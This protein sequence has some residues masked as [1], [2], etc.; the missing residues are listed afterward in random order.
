M[1]EPKV[2]E[3]VELKHSHHMLVGHPSE[4]R[5]NF[6]DMPMMSIMNDSSRLAPLNDFEINQRYA[7]KFHIHG[8][9]KYIIW[10]MELET[11]VGQPLKL[12]DD[13]RYEVD[14]LNLRLTNSYHANKKL[15][16]TNEHH[17]K[18]SII[19]ENKADDLRQK[20]HTQKSI[21]Y[22]LGVCLVIAGAVAMAGF[23]VI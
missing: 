22:V 23:N 18:W 13:L 17:R 1:N 5:M 9:D 2:V 4:F 3:V 11:L 10:S 7:K 15:E 19:Y 21:S 16:K 14:R 12:F 8:E 20:V 6:M